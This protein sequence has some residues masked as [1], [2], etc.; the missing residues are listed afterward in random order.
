MIPQQATNAIRSSTSWLDFV[1]KALKVSR[2][3]Y[4]AIAAIVA[5]IV[6]NQADAR[7]SRF[8]IY[9]IGRLWIECVLIATLWL[10][11]VFCRRLVI[12]AQEH[13]VEGPVSKT[14]MTRVAVLSLANLALLLALVPPLVY[15]VKVRYFLWK[16]AV[17]SS[18][19]ETA[20][21]HIDEQAKTGALNSAQHTL[22]IVSEVTKN[23][24][25]QSRLDY[26]RAKLL[27][28]INRSNDLDRTSM[29]QINYVTQRSAFFS[30]VEAVRLNPEN[31]DAADRLK[32]QVQIVK[33]YLSEDAN[34]I[35]NGGGDLRSFTGKAVAMIEAQS[36]W[37]R[38]GAS[39]NCKQSVKDDL[40]DGW[41]IAAISCILERNDAL[42]RHVTIGKSGS[43]PPGKDFWTPLSGMQSELEAPSQPLQ[44]EHPFYPTWFD[45][46]HKYKQRQP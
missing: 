31:S 1:D 44:Y 30:L 29:G 21:A 5:V 12:K 24:A 20:K 26:R 10:L 19:V 41:G 15:I 16:N 34:A 3:V 39:D 43:C 36:F 42:R 14:A 46:W 2:S 25:Y 32:D 23:T 22:E 4:V 45:L 40:F 7:R 17:L 9:V 37:E 8:T 35:C 33:T 11:Y 6:A 27:A 13:R 18:Y 28:M 38:H